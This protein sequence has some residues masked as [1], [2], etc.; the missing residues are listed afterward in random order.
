MSGNKFIL[1]TNIVVYILAGDEVL[2]ELLDGQEL[3]LSVISEME[4]L[5]YKKITKSEREKIKAFLKDFIIIEI[6]E[7]V[8]AKAIDIKRNTNLKLPD[9]IIAATS[10]YLKIPLLTADKQ[11]KTIQDFN[12]L[13]YEQ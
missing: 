4:L 9:S 13:S 12:L 5:S 6:I 3:Y 2:A 8:K 1:D 10:S 11:F 7:Q